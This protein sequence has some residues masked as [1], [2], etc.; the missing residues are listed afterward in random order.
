VTIGLD[1]DF[2]GRTVLV[3]GDVMLDTWIYG[4]IERISPEAPVPVLRTDRRREMLGGAGNVARNIAALGGHAILVSIV[5]DDPCGEQLRQLAQSKSLALGS[6]ELRLVTSPHVPTIH[7]VRY[8]AG[9]QQVLRVDEETVSPVEG[10]VAAQ[11]IGDFTRALPEAD[12][13]I[14]SDYA[15]GVLTDAVLERAIAEARSQGRPVVADPK[16]RDFSRYSGVT[17]LTP[18]RLETLTATGIDCSTDEKAEEAGNAVLTATNGDAVL[19]TRGADGVS[20]VSRGAPATH[21]AGRA[22]SVFDVSGAGDTLVATLALALASGQPLIDAARLANCAAGVVVEKAGTATLSARELVEA[23]HDTRYGLDSAKIM[24]LEGV[25]EHVARWRAVGQRVGFTNGCFDLLHPGHVMLLAKARA[26]CDKLIV[27]LNSDLSVKRL[28][29]PSRPIQNELARATVMASLAPVDLVV[30][31]E[32]D[33]PIELIEAIRPDLLVKGADYAEEDVVGGSFVRSYGG[34]V[35]LVPVEQ[36]HS[37]TGMVSRI[38][39]Q[40]NTT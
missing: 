21:V 35:F 14:L 24:P 22:R 39:D 9:G 36:G 7:K 25:L 29:G 1:L 5:G 19:I 12:V 38:A 31:F 10:A 33:T 13:V 40:P 30:L 11:L 17:V 20:V 4:H 15:K 6:I 34:R 27:G 28:K 32:Q 8:V 26:A 23:F 37:T 2:S 3:L 16:S 18:N